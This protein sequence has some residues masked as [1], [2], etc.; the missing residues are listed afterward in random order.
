[1]GSLSSLILFHQIVLQG[2][3][4][5]LKVYSGSEAAR[6]D[7]YKFLGHSLGN[8]DARADLRLVDELEGVVPIDTFGRHVPGMQTF[9]YVFRS[10]SEAIAYSGDNGDAAF[11]MGEVAKL[12]LPE[13]LRVFHELCFYPGVRAHAYYTDFDQWLGKIPVFGYHC[14]HRQAPADNRV[15]L[16]GDFPELNFLG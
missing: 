13:N 3:Q 6:Q 4:G 8:V 15:P 12:G 14:D 9:G 5:R 11:F 1:V 16:V 7:L 10:E 2:G